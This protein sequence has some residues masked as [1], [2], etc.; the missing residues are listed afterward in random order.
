MIERNNSVLKVNTN[1]L[2][3]S[4]NDLSGNMIGR[5]GELLSTYCFKWILFNRMYRRP[6]KL[7]LSVNSRI[8]L[9]T[10]GLELDA[11]LED[12]VGRRFQTF[13]N[14]DVVSEA[15]KVCLLLVS[16]CQWSL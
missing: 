14:K 6:L 12:K 15:T 5:T 7:Q 8:F 1:N 16:I 13:F 11:G 3:E 9:S 10:T 4:S 2:F